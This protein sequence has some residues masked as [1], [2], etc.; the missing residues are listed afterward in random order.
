MLASM[1]K[2]LLSLHI[3]FDII[4]WLILKLLQ[5][6][7]KMKQ[8]QSVLFREMDYLTLRINN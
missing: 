4:S 7:L 6:N 2:I 5:I 1:G 8:N 3:L